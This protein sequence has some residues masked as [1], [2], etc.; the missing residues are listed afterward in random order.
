M[1][2][3]FPFLIGGLERVSLAHCLE[4]IISGLSILMLRMH[5][6]KRSC[7]DST[8]GERGHAKN[9]MTTKN[10]AL[11]R[12]Q[13][14]ETRVIL[15]YLFSEKPLCVTT[16]QALKQTLKQMSCTRNTSAAVDAKLLLLELFA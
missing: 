9:Q 8:F 2:L 16:D 1:H 4:K 15:S 11:G 6:R 13:L 12:T 3:R 14:D 7:I 10:L 5:R